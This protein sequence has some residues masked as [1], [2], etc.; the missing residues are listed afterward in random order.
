MLL[1]RLVDLEAI[2]AGIHL[3]DLH[4]LHAVDQ[5][6]H[7]FNTR[8]KHWMGRKAVREAFHIAI[9]PYNSSKQVCDQL[10][11]FQE[12]FNTVKLEKDGELCVARINNLDPEECSLAHKAAKSCSCCLAFLYHHGL[13]NID[14]YDGWGRNYFHG[15]IDAKN[16]SALKWLLNE[17][18]KHFKTAGTVEDEPI[19]RVLKHA[20]EQRWLQGC[21]LII[22]H[23]L[24]ELDELDHCFDDEIKLGLCA[25]V[26]ITLAEKLLEERIDISTVGIEQEGSTRNMTTSWHA[27][28]AENPHGDKFMEWL[29]E[30]SSSGPD[31]MDWQDCSPLHAAAG[32]VTP[33]SVEW[34][35]KRLLHDQPQEG[36]GSSNY[37]KTSQRDEGSGGSESEHGSE[38][39]KKSQVESIEIAALCPQ[40]HSKDIFRVLV[41]HW[42]SHKSNIRDMNSVRI[43]FEAICWGAFKA[44]RKEPGSK[45]KIVKTAAKKCRRLKSKLGRQWLNCNQRKQLLERVKKYEL[46][47]LTHSMTPETR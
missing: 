30:N 7:L 39:R 25:F 17:Q 35:C 43:V 33:A 15:A 10:S 40:V 42:A 1:D 22:D 36:R 11:E 41:K 13:I 27:A 24:E 44:I 4:V 8:V 31:V 37:L 6:N 23:M 2:Y 9:R 14:G 29:E 46:E 21:E 5:F 32:G 28:A 3:E 47:G 19:V 26:P 34:L 45:S 20:V 38:S 18:K 12:T 16:E